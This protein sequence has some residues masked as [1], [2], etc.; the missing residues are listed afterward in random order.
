MLD[1]IW[2][3]WRREYVEN[4]I[5]TSNEIDAADDHGSVFTRI[6][7]S[8]LSDIDAHI[9]WRG[10]WCFAIMNAYPYT[11]GHL[12]VMPYREIADV[13]RLSAD[14]FTELWD[15]VRMGVSAIKS[16]YSPDGLNI[17]M[18]LGAAAGA[19]V[20]THLHA[21]VLP[22]WNGDTNAMTT[23]AE[24]RVMP[25]A[26]ASSAARIR[27]AWIGAAGVDTPSVDARE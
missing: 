14:E 6:L 2:A 21:H 11:N 1:R 18:N 23:I 13:E 10:S 25:E 17:G 4:T 24:V 12:L 5:D 20:P 7:K 3:G 22:R 26:L 15:G 8:G 19:G 16:V 9:V 27:K